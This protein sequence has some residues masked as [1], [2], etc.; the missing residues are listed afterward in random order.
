[1]AN[2]QADCS[3]MLIANPG[4]TETIMINFAT[5]YTSTIEEAGLRNLEEF[6]LE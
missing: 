3:E 4:D 5:D 6:S 1:M 2:A